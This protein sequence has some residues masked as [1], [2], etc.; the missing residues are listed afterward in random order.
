MKKPLYICL[1]ALALNIYSCCNCDDVPDYFDITGM[2]VQLTKKN[3]TE[4]IDTNL[5]V[6]YDNFFIDISFNKTFY[7]CV[8]NKLDLQNLLFNSLY[9]CKCVEAGFSGSKESIEGIFVF[10]NN[11]FDSIGTASDTLNKYFEISGS[12]SNYSTTAF[13]DLNS[14]I[15]TKPNAFTNFSLRLKKAP[16]SALKH[17]FTIIYKQTNGEVYSAKTPTIEFVK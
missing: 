14:V 11:K 8:N 12:K 9:A 1:V 15:L 10:S 5:A 4:S 6:A 16:S 2:K 13:A 7:S 17:E 3:K